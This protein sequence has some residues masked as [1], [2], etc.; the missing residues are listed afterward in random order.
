M[1]RGTWIAMLAA[2]AIACA[3]QT[4]SLPQSAAA[5]L[6]VAIVDGDAVK[7][8]RLIA[9]DFLWVRGNGEV[10]GRADFIS[11]LTDSDL[12]LDPI[13]TTDPRWFLGQGQALSSQ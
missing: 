10:A 2:L 3:P 12:E 13:R 11:A 8:E 7:L 6:D 1:P 4:P 9:A 5:A